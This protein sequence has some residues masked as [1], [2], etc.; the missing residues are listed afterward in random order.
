MKTIDFDLFDKWLDEDLYIRPKKKR[1]EII[2]LYKRMVKSNANVVEFEQELE[3]LGWDE[4]TTKS[5]SDYL[6]IWNVKDKANTRLMKKQE[7]YKF[8]KKFMRISVKK[9]CEEEQIT[10][11]NLITGRASAYNMKIVRERLEEEIRKLME[12]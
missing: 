11:S 7:D 10:Y 8:I 5:I 2:S 1:T 6:I 9:I 4:T 3:K 12:Q